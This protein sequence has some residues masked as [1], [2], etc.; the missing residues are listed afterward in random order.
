MV[1]QELIGHYQAVMDGDRSTG[2]IDADAQREVLVWLQ[3][4]VSTGPINISVANGDA[5]SIAAGIGESLRRYAAARTPSQPPPT[6]GKPM[7]SNA[8]RSGPQKVGLK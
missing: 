8:L 3:Q 4:R 2:P 5:D 1:T 7:P 6:H